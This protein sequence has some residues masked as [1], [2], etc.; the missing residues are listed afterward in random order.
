MHVVKIE[1]KYRISMNIMEEIDPIIIRLGD[2][3]DSDDSDY[4][5]SDNNGD[6]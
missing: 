2:D 4:T 5:E 6:I 1:D 3:S